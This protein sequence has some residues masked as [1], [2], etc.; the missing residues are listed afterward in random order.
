MYKAVVPRFGNSTNTV[1]E[2]WEACSRGRLGLKA[3]AVWDLSFISIALL[4]IHNDN[5]L[6]LITKTRGQPA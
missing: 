5:K 3:E 4:V 1:G 6:C 2:K